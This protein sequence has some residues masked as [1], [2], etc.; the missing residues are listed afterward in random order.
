[1]RVCQPN[2][3]EKLS[4]QICSGDWTRLEPVW[5]VESI[6]NS[7]VLFKKIRGLLTAK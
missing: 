6:E 1:L 7:D 5:W 2:P 3:R 4:G